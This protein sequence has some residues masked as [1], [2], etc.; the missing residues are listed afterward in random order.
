M[1]NSGKTQLDTNK[2]LILSLYESNAPGS[3]VHTSK[4]PRASEYAKINE[5]MYDWYVL[6]APKN[7]FSMGPQLVEKAK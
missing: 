2:D 1:F 4:A 5:V 3:G 7:I 6:A